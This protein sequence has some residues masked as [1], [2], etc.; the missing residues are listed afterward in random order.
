MILPLGTLMSPGTSSTTE[1]SQEQRRWLE[2]SQR[3]ER[4]SRTQ[5]GLVDKFHLLRETTQSQLG[6]LAIL[7]EVQKNK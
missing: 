3:F 6:E 4:E 2:Q 7:S 1:R 5:A